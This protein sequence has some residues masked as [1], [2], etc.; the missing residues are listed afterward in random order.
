MA[1]F[2]AASTGVSNNGN[3]I[4]AFNPAN[5]TDGEVGGINARKANKKLFEF[6]TNKIT[7]PAD[8]QTGQR[9]NE[10]T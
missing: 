5:T 7:L 8:G 6:D 3:S 2:E 10:L 1:T 9:M 4:I